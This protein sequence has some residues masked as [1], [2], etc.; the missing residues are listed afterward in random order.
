MKSHKAHI[1]AYSNIDI[2][3]EEGKTEWFL[4]AERSP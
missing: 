1:N 3:K 4:C 2:N